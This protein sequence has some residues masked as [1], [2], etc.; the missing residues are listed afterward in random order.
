VVGG[1]PG[2][3]VDLPPP[4]PPPPAPPKVV[5]AAA[6]EPLRIAGVKEIVPDLDTKAQISADHRERVIATLK[7]CVDV[8][9]S[10]FKVTPLKSSGYG[11]YDARLVAEIKNWKYRPFVVD[12]KAVPVCT[13][14]T[15][16]YSQHDT[17]SGSAAP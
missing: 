4:P 12:G 16:I 17:P 5:A 1:V 14:A 15:F 2:G 7:L 9:G 8:D 13:A 6:L 10:V 11:A 3:D